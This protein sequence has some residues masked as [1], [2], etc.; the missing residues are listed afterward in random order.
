MISSIEATK[1]KIRYRRY[2]ELLRSNQPIPADLAAHF[3]VCK[4]CS[5]R[6]QVGYAFIDNQSVCE[7]DEPCP[8]CE[9]DGFIQINHAE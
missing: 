6:G 8:I 5:G 1:R 3:T 9:G 7:V 4:N 2:S